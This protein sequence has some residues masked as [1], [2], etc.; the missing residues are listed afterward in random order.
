MSMSAA[1]RTAS[2]SLRAVSRGHGCE[3]PSSQ[4]L[5]APQAPQAPY[6]RPRERHRTAVG[7]GRRQPKRQTH[8]R[9]MARVSRQR[10][11]PDSPQRR[12]APCASRPDCRAPVSWSHREPGG[13]SHQVLTGL[14]GASSAGDRADGAVPDR[15]RKW[16]RASGSGFEVRAPGLAGVGRGWPMG[17]SLLPQLPDGPAKNPPPNRIRG[18]LLVPR[19]RNRPCKPGVS[20]LRAVRLLEN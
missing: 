13:Q 5:P 6:C 12:V 1:T 20:S 15:Q 16:P 19:I 9:G 10:S 8:C 14:V 11:A 18:A 3:V 4:Q 17:E 7:R 2:H